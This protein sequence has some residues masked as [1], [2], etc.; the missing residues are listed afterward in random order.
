MD[1]L[2]AQLIPSGDVARDAARVSEI[3]EQNTDAGL[4][5]FPELFIGG[6][7]TADPGPVAI[8]A[9]GAEL[10]AISDSCARHAT[11]AVFG[12]TER[13]GGPSFANSAACFDRD[14][15][16]AGIYRKTH[17]FGT[18]EGT[19]F[20]PGRELILVDLADTRVGPM[21]CFDMEFPETARL[22][23]VSGARLLVTLS[24][25]MAPYGPDHRVAACARALD[26]RLPHIYVNRV[27]SVPGIEFIGGSCVIGPDGSVRHDAGTA[28]GVFEF[29]CQLD[30]GLA[31]EVDYL[32]QLRTDLVVSIPNVSSGGEL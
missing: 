31:P 16:L 3:L 15:R 32:K 4:A 19:F 23:A 11:A 10:T 22:L 21:I 28:E 14:G 25:N 26:N 12:F 1:V 13:L 2:L 6:Y 7:E 29:S 8:D 24:A 30:Q 9:D 5:V 27:G 20:D 17:L 18:S